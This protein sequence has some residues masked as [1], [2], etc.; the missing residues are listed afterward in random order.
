MSSAEVG[1]KA[2]NEAGA[3][4]TGRWPGKVAG[5]LESVEGRLIF[6]VGMVFGGIAGAL[7][8]YLGS[9]HRH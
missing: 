1:R 2:A 3:A 4:D 9:Y 7:A 8:T 6:G 5:S